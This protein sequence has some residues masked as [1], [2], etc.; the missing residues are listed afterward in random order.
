MLSAHIPS[1]YLIAH[2]VPP[3]NSP[4]FGMVGFVIAG[5]LLPDIDMIAFFLLDHGSFHHRHYW[6]HIPM[7][8]LIVFAMTL[9]ALSLFESLVSLPSSHK[10]MTLFFGGILGHLLVDTFTGPV[11]WL[12]PLTTTPFE[13]IEVPATRSHWVLSYILHWSFAA[14]IALWLGAA[15]TFAVMQTK[16]RRAGRHAS[17][18]NVSEI[19]ISRDRKSD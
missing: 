17:S 6:T 7:F 9:S 8:W 18:I 10:Y 15:W 12:Y 11:L 4:T 16:K 1:G 2:H 5:S 13:L 3:A 19:A 14:E